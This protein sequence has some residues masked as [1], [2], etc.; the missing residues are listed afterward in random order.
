MTAEAVC[1][2]TTGDQSAEPAGR[3]DLPGGWYLVRDDDSNSPHFKEWFL[4]TP[5]GPRHREGC[6]VAKFWDGPQAGQD[7]AAAFAASI[8]KA[9]SE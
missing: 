2:L 9:L 7:D 8:S 6:W 3:I 4:S 5:D 1:D